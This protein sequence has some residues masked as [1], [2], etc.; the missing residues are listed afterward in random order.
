MIL[1]NIEVVINRGTRRF[2]SKKGK[3][4]I[5]TSYVM[6]LE[7]GEVVDADLF[8]ADQMNYKSGSK[9]SLRVTKYGQNPN[10]RQMELTGFPPAEK[11]A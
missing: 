7:D 8:G 9:I 6:I 3:P 2:T 11:S 10:T 5:I 4:V 1:K